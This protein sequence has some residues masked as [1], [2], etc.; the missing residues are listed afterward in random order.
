MDHAP[1][2]I[3]AAGD[4]ALDESAITKLLLAIAVMLGLA[5]VLGE[6]CRKFGQ[7]AVLGEIVAGIILGPTILGS[8]D[9][10]GVDLSW[11]AWAWQG[12]ETYRLPDIGGLTYAYLFPAESGSAAWIAEEG[13]ITLSA[14]LLLFVVGLEVDL[15]AVVR[16]GKAMV[17]VSA[18]GIVIPFALGFGAAT[19]MTGLLGVGERAQDNLLPFQIFCGLAMSITA[20][21]V[22]AK[23]LIDLN[24]SK[25]D[26]GVLVISSAMCND[27]IG[28]IGFAVVLALLPPVVGGDGATVTQGASLGVAGTIGATVVFLAFMLTLGRLFMHKALPY[29]QARWSWPGGVIS[30]AF[31]IAMACAALTEF[32]G[33]HSIFGAFIAGVA[34]GDSHHLRERTRDTIHQFVMNIFAP[35]FFASIGLTI[36]FLDAFQLHTVAIVCFI[37]L[38][39]KVSGCYLGAK[40]AGLSPRESWA[41]GFG[42]AAQGAVGIILGQLA[43]QAELISE[44]LMV[45]IVIMALGTSIL[46]GPAMQRILQVKSQRKLQDFLTD[47]HIMLDPEAGDIESLL[48]AMSKRAVELTEIEEARIFK[49]V[50]ARESVMHTALPNGLAVPHARLE[51]LSKPTVIV[52]RSTTGVDFDAP[53]GQL[54]KLIFLLLT[55]TDQPATQL[56]LLAL[57]AKT[58]GEADTRARCLQVSS[59]TEFRAVLNLATSAD[60]IIEHDDETLGI[61]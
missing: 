22:I 10:S 48:H 30:F 3:L 44:E 5:R 49:E 6:L 50:W 16:Q 2:L 57:V 20:L 32:L 58:F 39:G 15:S 1:L 7:P 19:L 56:E 33:I 17:L 61:R 9:P 54:A 13:F 38:V 45:A 51:E 12:F 34:I 42:M 4:S 27:L 14:A 40:F 35:V 59:A 25:S 21:P 60:S 55:P 31:V 28:W 26:M 24:L 52:A 29:V 37:A 23:I 11:L 46:A 8:F 53:D 18:M 36:N 43:Y 41:V 47:R